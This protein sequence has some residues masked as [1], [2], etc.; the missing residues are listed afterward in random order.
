MVHLGGGVADTRRFGLRARLTLNV[1]FAESRGSDGPSNIAHPRPGGL[2]GIYPQQ[3]GGNE[4]KLGKRLVKFFSRPPGA[5]SRLRF[6]R[7]C[8]KTGLELI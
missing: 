8:M 5:G 7:A 6:R 4:H 2:D 3:T 1:G